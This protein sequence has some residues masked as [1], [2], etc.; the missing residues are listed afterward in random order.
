MRRDLAR[1]AA[2]V[3][4]YR[5]GSTYRQI[6][7]HYGLSTERVR[8]LLR[9]A[10][11]P[12][13]RKEISTAQVAAMYTSGMSGGRIATEIGCTPDTVYRHLCWAGIK[14]RPRGQQKAA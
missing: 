5:A 9:Q 3:A 14:R 8:Q 13:R 4:M 11:E 6:G 10:N 1:E 2:I 12:A 7:A